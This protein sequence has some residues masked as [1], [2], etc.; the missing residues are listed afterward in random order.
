MRLAITILL[1]LS[2][3]LFVGCS[4]NQESGRSTI[5][6][7]RDVSGITQEEIDAVNALR[8]EG[9]EFIYAV[10]P[11]EEAFIHEDGT[12]GGFAVRFTEWLSD[13]FDLPFE[14]EVTPWPELIGGLQEG[15]FDFTAQLIH[16]EDFGGQLYAAGPILLRGIDY[17]ALADTPELQNLGRP[18][19]FAV[20]PGT[21]VQNSLLEAGVFEHFDV[22]EVD[23]YQALAYVVDGTVDAFLGMRV[24]GMSLMHPQIISRTVYPPVFRT[25]DFYAVDPELFP[26]VQILQ[27]YLDSGGIQTL[28]EF[29]FLGVADF[30]LHQYRFTLTEEEVAFMDRGGS[31]RLGV[32]SATYP[33][34][35]YN[36]LE[37]EMQG[38]AIDIFNTLQRNSNLTYELY[39]AHPSE[40]QRMVDMLI[41]GELDYLLSS[42]DSQDLVGRDV[43]VTKPIFRDNFIFISDLEFYNLDFNG[44][45]YLHVG[46]VANSVHE[47]VFFEY[48]P[49]HRHITKFHDQRELMYALIDGE[50]DVVF[51]GNSTL[52]YL[53]NFLGAANFY[54]NLVLQSEYYISFIATDELLFSLLNNSL[55]RM[56]AMAITD[57]WVGRTF[58]YTARLVSA[59]RPWLIS[60]GI[61]FAIVFFLTIALFIHRMNLKKT[62]AKR[63][64]ELQK[65]IVLVNTM[66]EAAPDLIFYKDKNLKYR[67]FNRAFGDLFQRSYDEILGKD[68]V[69]ALGVPRDM[70]EDFHEWDKIVLYEGKNIRTEEIVHA[71]DGT[72]RTFDTIKAPLITPDGKIFGLFGLSRDITMRKE[73]EEIVRQASETKTA[74][75]ANMSH[76]IRTPMNSIVG[77]SELAM[78][79][80]L[81]ETKVYLSRITENANWL[82][83]IIDSILDISK[84]E[85][86]KMELDHIAFNPSD[87]F[88]Q[89]R[90]IILPK[91]LE[92]ELTIDFHVDN[93]NSEKL[94]LG[95][96]VRLRQILLNVIYN[97][98]K[99]TESGTIEVRSSLV[100]ET[101]TTQTI[102]WEVKDTGIGMSE[103]QISKIFE[104]FVQ[105]DSSI[106]RKYG[107][108]GLGISIVNSMLEV[109]NSELKIESKLGVGSKFSFEITFDSMG[110]KEVVSMHEATSL[111]EKPYFEGEVLICEDNPIN[112]L[113]ITENLQR[114][115]LSYV[116][117]S[118]GQAGVSLV[119]ERMKNNNPFDIILM[120]IHMPV[121]GGMEAATS[122]IEMGCKT[123]IIALTAN[124]MPDD[125]RA[126]RKVGMMDCL[127][128]PF[129]GEDLWAVLLKYLTPTNGVESGDA[130]SSQSVQDASKKQGSGTPPHGGN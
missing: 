118:D 10:I 95:D 63:T 70:A 104:P 26:I 67:R 80:A 64:E 47:R 21:I 111:I 69:E 115:G 73:A 55:A 72:M 68:A 124:I 71:A 50:V 66:F 117:V 130:D 35:F 54:A 42:K 36:E 85:A 46:A 43:L 44:I 114:I 107:G 45:L 98:V 62:I 101:E 76:E 122:I 59:Q 51:A 94:P 119:A 34:S 78:E 5:S 17:A 29:Y 39:V 129:T 2:I 11:G 83:Q 65:E 108:T 27:R 90:N 125:R 20:T 31:V 58:D 75:I 77:F 113:V 18:P 13:F 22:I 93:M 16:A 92:K 106:T 97:A 4:T 102:Y 7:Y 48:F 89:C 1:S 120:D 128:K 6:S 74:F 86:G 91:A 25:A 40:F 61:L 23:F 19:R 110:A 109:M 52:M 15:R 87:L 126:Y 105:G 49:Y 3:L 81:P 37:G 33:V 121:M 100:R 84:I 9:R 116:T 82:L 99:F 103:D 127:G 8:A 88:V 96:P 56:N 32:I 30:R 57:R 24:T 112:Q 41:A 12:L 79:G 14:V 38:I 60:A 28:G 123:P 53:N